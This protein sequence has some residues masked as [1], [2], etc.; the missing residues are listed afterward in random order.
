MLLVKLMNWVSI[1]KQNSFYLPT[2]Q[3][4]RNTAFMEKQGIY[5]K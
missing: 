4:I 3:S 2:E 5:Y 1:I